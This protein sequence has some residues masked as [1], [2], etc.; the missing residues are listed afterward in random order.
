M[1]EEPAASPPDHLLGPDDGPADDAAPYGAIVIGA[2]MAGRLAAAA[3]HPTAG[4]VLILDRDS[5]PDAPEVRRC[6]G[7]GAQA[8]L[9]LDSGREAVA[10][11]LP[12]I[13]DEIVADGGLRI[14]F[15][16]ELRWY[17]GGQYKVRCDT[18]F[19]SQVQ[20]R[21][22]LEQHVRRRVLALPGV[23][24]R[25]ETRVTAL[26]IEGGRVRGVLAAR[27][28]GAPERIEAPIVVDA[29]GRGSQVVRWLE[30]VGYRAPP[31]SEVA[32]GIGY[33]SRLYRRPA[34]AGPDRATVIYGTRARTKRHGVGFE[35]EGG[36]WLVTLIGY[37]GDHPPTDADAFDAWASTLERPDLADS[38]VGAEPLSE[39]RTF[40]APTQ[41]RLRFDRVALP[42][43][44][45]V[46]G[47]AACAL[48][49]VFGQGM[50][51]AAV[52]AARLR[53]HLAARPF[54]SRAV[55]RLVARCSARAWLL[56]SVEA[57]RYREARAIP[58]IGLLHGFLDKIGEVASYDAAVYTAFLEVMHLHRGAL[59]LARP[60]FLLRV[61]AGRSL[62]TRARP[63]V[64]VHDAR[65]SP[66]LRSVAE[67]GFTR[68]HERGA[69][70]PSHD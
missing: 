5:L 62:P 41:R 61:L 70:V 47:D 52:T 67:G 33:A 37:H 11:L 27:S 68:V 42:E 13:F 48:D 6:V 65:S 43:G 64:P 31:V 44:L 7:Q 22:L 66:T 59:H 56:T 32:L 38:L 35:V 58:G 10:S 12:G 34:T 14:D 40:K 23:T 55:A 53:D 26:V 30:E 45:A 16:H 46:V 2:S 4:R 24:L 69:G 39:V 18:R 51:V 25:P 63:L 15:G 50:S 19:R 57:M 49:P 21:P 3:L 1:S 36:R 60:G 28:G 8:H 54:A 20:T 17:H 9:L 29:A